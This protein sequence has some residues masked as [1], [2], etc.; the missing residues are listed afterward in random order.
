MQ[1]SVPAAAEEVPANAAVLEDNKENPTTAT[2]IHAS[3]IQAQAE[4]KIVVET[5]SASESSRQAISGGASQDS[6]GQQASAA[7]APSSQSTVA[8]D[9]TPAE[10]AELAAAASMTSFPAGGAMMATAVA[11]TPSARPLSGSASVLS[12]IM[13]LTKAIV[14]AGVL[15]LPAGLV[16]FYTLSTS[17]AAAPEVLDELGQVVA[18]S[19]AA[20]AATGGSSLG[21]SLFGP[22]LLLIATIG[23]ASALGFDCIASVCDATHATSYRQAWASTVS[24]TSSWIPA[25]AC[26]LV[27]TCTTVTCSMILKSTL[28]T[29]TFLSV[30]LCVLL[31]LCLQQS[32]KKL[33]PFSVIGTL[34]MLYTAVVMAIRYMTGAYTSASKFEFLNDMDLKYRP[35]GLVSSAA[36]AAQRGV[37]PWLGLLNIKKGAILISMLS[38][39]F[40][41]HYNAPKLYWEL[42]QTS[43]QRFRKVI[44]G[45]FGSAILLMSTI[46][47]SGFLT[48]G[49]ASS[50]MILN[51]YAPTDGLASIAK[52][53]VTISVIFTVPLAFVGVRDGVLDLCR[54]EPE[55]RQGRMTLMATL[56][57]LAFITSM[58]LLLKDIR[59]VLALGGSTWGM[60]VIYLFPALMVI[61]GADTYPILRPKV[62]LAR[63]LAA[64]G[65]VVGSMGIYRT[66][67]TLL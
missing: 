43:P 19:A 31:P 17:L 26:L 38:T 54:V 15:G 35:L 46:A 48:F 66:L 6:M 3:S 52:A 32:L 20:T 12:E 9:H 61:H 49:A 55:K 59:I 7:M 47:L 50:G 58:A 67:T 39:S 14:G 5:V 34:G 1:A 57:G 60:C 65:L 30:T 18:D 25:L 33:A 10:N 23:S 36:T 40:M 56:G 13:T 45:G 22:T 64:M 41:A 37:N 53:A 44:I 21:R 24:P 4:K 28:G 2:A 11:K 42:Q 27:T 16:T 29:A 8:L 63:T 62:P 51:N